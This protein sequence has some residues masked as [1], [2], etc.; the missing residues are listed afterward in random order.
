MSLASLPP[1]TD[2]KWEC[3]FHRAQVSKCKFGGQLGEASTN[4]KVERIGR[5][6]N[7]EQQEARGSASIRGNEGMLAC[8]VWCAHVGGLGASSACSC[9]A[10]S[11]GPQPSLSSRVWR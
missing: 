6:K 8:S 4:Q 11:A 7:Q 1:C 9:Q 3:K 2:P 5:G 10:P